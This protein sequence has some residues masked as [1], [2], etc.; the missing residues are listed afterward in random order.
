MRAS[1][2]EFDAHTFTTRSRPSSSALRNSW[3]ALRCRLTHIEPFHSA[4]PAS[5]HHPKPPFPGAGNFAHSQQVALSAS[6]R[7]SKHQQ[8]TLVESASSKHVVVMLLTSD[9]LRWWLHSLTH[10][11]KSRYKWKCFCT[12]CRNSLIVCGT[13]S[14]L[15]NLSLFFSYVAA[16]AIAA[17]TGTWV[18]RNTAE[19]R[20]S[21]SYH[22]VRGW[23]LPTSV[24]NAISCKRWNRET[25]NAP[26]QQQQPSQYFSSQLKTGSSV[27]AQLATWVLNR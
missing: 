27:C 6:K 22:S 20:D 24:K 17:V 2:Q 19:N 3:P 13:F 26:S 11:D 25:Y 9:N 15:S 5:S 21:C 16:P 7:A 23:L 1:P 4:C 18:K 10:V 8:Q 14:P 12:P